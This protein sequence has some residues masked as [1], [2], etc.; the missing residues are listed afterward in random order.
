MITINAHVSKKVPIEGRDYSSQSYSAGMEREVSGS[1]GEEK[2][3]EKFRRVYRLLEK[4]IDEQMK[5]DEGSRPPSGLPQGNNG[6]SDSSHDGNGRKA[7]RAQVKA[8]HAIAR[9]RG[10]NEDDLAA[11]IRDSEGVGRPGFLHL[12]L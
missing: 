8:I 2:I 9:D 7:T 6:S 11:H 10:V 4:C 3:K 5:A 12:C 1:A